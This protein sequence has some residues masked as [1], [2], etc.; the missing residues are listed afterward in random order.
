MQLETVA[1]V[2][3]FAQDDKAFQDDQAFHDANSFVPSRSCAPSNSVPA[4]HFRTQ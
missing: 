2:L 1:R 3:R 4:K